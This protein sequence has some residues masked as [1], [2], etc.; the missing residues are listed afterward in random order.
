MDC[1]QRRTPPHPASAWDGSFNRADGLNNRERVP[2][3]SS[4]SRTGD[5]YIGM[6]EK[7]ARGAL[8]IIIKFDVVGSGDFRECHDSAASRSRNKRIAFD[9]SV[10]PTIRLDDVD[11]G[12]AGGNEDRRYLDVLIRVV[13]LTELVKVSAIPTDKGFRSL[14]GVFHPLA[15]CFYSIA[16]GFEVDPIVASRELQMA[17]L[18]PMVKA[19]EFPDSMVK[20]APQI[21]DSVAYYR[22]ES[23][24]RFFDE[25]NT[26]IERSS[27]RVALDAKSVWFFGDENS[28][29]PLKVSNVV[30]GPLD[31]LFGA[32][33]Q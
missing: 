29:L 21:V 19:N 1:K 10:N 2:L 9:C 17:I 28:E 12:M 7:Y 5:C 33:E 24:R 14:D 26:D 18:R 25:T 3:Q 30:I 27:Y 13:Q 32:V 11:R 22:G 4:N 6:A 23:A 16:G 15:G 8:S 20:S 31:F